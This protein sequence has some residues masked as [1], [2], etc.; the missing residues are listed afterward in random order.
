MSTRSNP[1]PAAFD[2]GGIT[3]KT[4][5]L[6]LVFAL[7][8][9]AVHSHAS[10]LQVPTGSAYDEFGRTLGRSG[11]MSL[12]G[13]PPVASW[14]GAAYLFRNIDEPGVLAPSASLVAGDGISGD[15]FGDSVAISGGLGIVAAPLDD[16][17]GTDSGSVYVFHGLETATG[18]VSHSAK[19]L[20][21]DG[22]KNARFG[23]AT[24]LSGTTAL[25][26]APE[27]SEGAANSGGAY[28]FRN[29]DTASGIVGQSVKLRESSAPRNGQY[30]GHAVALSG[31]LGVVGA[32]GDDTAEVNAGAAYVFRNLDTASG[33]M[34]EHA[35]LVASDAIIDQRFGYSVGVSGTTAVVGAPR[36][37]P[38]GARSGAV[39]VY[40]GLDTATGLVTEHAKLVASDDFQ[41][42]H[43]LGQ[44]VSVSG[45][46]A[47]V[48][49]FSDD[50]KGSDS[51]SAYLYRNLDTVTGTVTE[52][53][54]LTAS[55]PHVNDYFGWSV[56]LSGDGFVIGAYEAD[57]A[58]VDS[59]KA[60]TGTVS[61]V[62]TLDV[63]HAARTIDGI[64]FRSQR[65]WVI[66]AA[67]DF[68][69]VTL[70]EGDA[71][72]VTADGRAVRV[73]REAGAD[74][75]SLIVRGSLTA[76]A[77]FVGSVDGNVGN[78]FQ[79]DS[80]AEFVI[81]SISLAMDNSLSVEGDYQTP[82]D[83]LD[84]LGDTELRVWTGGAW[85]TVSLENFHDLVQTD[86]VGAHTL[87]TAVPEPGV[88]ALLG[89]GLAVALARLRRRR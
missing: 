62:T 73:G 76:T 88:L 58:V 52:D 14:T 9:G 5:F 4:P 8:L 57:G 89:G 30:F 21:I 7:A 70:T 35:K 86:F 87:V 67:S 72:Q 75:N 41:A 36:S 81:E 78:V 10:Q 1:T 65:D 54:K 3:R 53:V 66:G 79:L 48:G 80:S 26:G 12:V 84:F 71:A 74:F 56:S 28:V 61:S 40:R 13:A 22:D 6:P 24:S 51:G 50:S 31:S 17:Q 82:A 32:Y 11:S 37:D 29:L 25:I 39:Y 33:E 43:L 34:T 83:L 60:Y 23:A 27:R 69:S 19:L 45:N 20:P 15:R 2:F 64:S 16:D 44:A 85:E 38:K 47:L 55:D 59:G 63:G 49:A 46:V 68:N 77:V 18:T 42:G